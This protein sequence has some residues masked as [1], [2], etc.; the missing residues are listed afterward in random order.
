MEID[1]L[2]SRPIRSLCSLAIGELIAA[3]T[4]TY[5]PTQLPGEDLS[6]TV[7]VEVVITHTCLVLQNLSA[8]FRSMRSRAAKIISRVQSVDDQDC[9]LSIR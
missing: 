6:A 8:I 7:V 4:N 1:N 5:H 9:H 2:S 3:K